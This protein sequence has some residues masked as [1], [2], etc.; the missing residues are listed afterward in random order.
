MTHTE[1]RLKCAKDIAQAAGQLA[2]SLLQNKSADFV[3]SKGLQDFVTV[4]D[5]QVEAFIRDQIASH[6]PND[7]VLGEEAG[8]SGNSDC[9]WVVDPIDGTTNYMRGLPDW[10]VS[11]AC[12]HKGQAVFGVIYAPAR[13]DLCWAHQGQ[14]CYHNGSPVK[15]SECRRN[16][17]ALILLGRSQRHPLGQYL[18]LIDRVIAAGMEYRRNGSAAVSL[19]DVALGRAE[20]FYE[21]HLNAWDALAGVVLIQEAGGLVTCASVCDFIDM[22]SSVLAATPGIQ[23]SL[24]EV[25][26]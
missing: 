12:C 21:S 23:E 5:R 20:G 1:T 6:F 18:R 11:I 9:I 17:Q 24:S 14:G 22:G 8:L 16:D 2:Q 13:D 10:A 19:M 26:P 4:A 3:D 25:I 7:A 15:V